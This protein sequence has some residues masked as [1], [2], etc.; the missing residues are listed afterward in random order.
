MKSKQKSDD[1]PLQK[2]I[3]ELIFNE[4]NS[5]WSICG[6]GHIKCMRSAGR[7]EG[8]NN[9]SPFLTALRSHISEKRREQKGSKLE[10]LLADD[11][12]DP[13]GESHFNAC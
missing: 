5:S 1:V 2:L 3:V 12:Q 9:G 10:N 13:S 6:L 8:E 4:F 11:P 7:E